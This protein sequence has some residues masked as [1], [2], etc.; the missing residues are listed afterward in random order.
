VLT[1]GADRLTLQ[2]PAADTVD[3]ERTA[4]EQR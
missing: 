3:A 2:L 4:D 1:I